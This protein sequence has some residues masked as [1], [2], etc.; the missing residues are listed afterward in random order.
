MIYFRESKMH[1]DSK[2]KYIYIFLLQ[3]NIILELIR[4]SFEHRF[5]DCNS[6]D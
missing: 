6:R 4:F 5:H 2:I 1:E 3:F